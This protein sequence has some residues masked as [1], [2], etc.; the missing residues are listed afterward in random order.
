MVILKAILLLWDKNMVYNTAHKLFTSVS[1]PHF[2]IVHF[3]IA[4][5]NKPSV[6]VDK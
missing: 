3:E 2:Q 1:K 4:N 6:N 5:S